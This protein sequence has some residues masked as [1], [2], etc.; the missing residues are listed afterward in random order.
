MNWKTTLT[1]CVAAAAGFV[2]FSSAHFSPLVVDLAKY[3]ML[4]GMA[5]LGIFAKDAT[6][7]STEAEVSKATGVAL[8]KAIPPEVQQE[9][10]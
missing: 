9:K 10:L 8:N 4:G 3:I 2:T 6:T 5:G 7:H 1:A